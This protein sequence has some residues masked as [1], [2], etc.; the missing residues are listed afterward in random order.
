MKKITFKLR[1]N[2]IQSVDKV[3]FRRYFFLSYPQKGKKRQFYLSE[4]IF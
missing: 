2:A 3:P 4:D 1:L